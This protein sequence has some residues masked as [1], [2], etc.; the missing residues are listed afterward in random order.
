M[1]LEASRLLIGIGVAGLRVSRWTNPI[2]QFRS[3]CAVGTQ[4]DSF[5]FRLNRESGNF[6]ILA[7][8]PRSD[9]IPTATHLVPPFQVT[10]F[11]FVGFESLRHSC[12]SSHIEMELQQTTRKWDGLQSQRLSPVIPAALQSL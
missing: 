7:H 2:C 12:L 9:L 5:G 6:E 1:I 8:D 10:N 11:F 3:N 4:E